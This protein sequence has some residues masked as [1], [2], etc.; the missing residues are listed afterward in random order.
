M[1]L[2]KDYFDCPHCDIKNVTYQILGTVPEEISDFDETSEYIRWGVFNLL[3]RCSRKEC[4]RV[5]YV[6]V[7]NNWNKKEI[8]Y[9]NANNQII[10]QYPSQK[11]DLPD[12]IPANIRKYFKEAVE[13]FSFGLY[14]SASMMCRKVIYE[15]CDK[16]SSGGEDYKEKIINLGFDKRIT[17]PLLN[18]KNI[19][20]DTVHANGW[21]KGTIK[22]ALEAVGIIIEMVY[23]QEQRI[24]QFSSSYSKKVQKN[25]KNS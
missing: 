14:N 7:I 23:V 4:Q 21:D 22:E 19:G 20:D 12:Y 16:K 5:T 15:L 6:R 2:D 18:I 11:N 1:Y 10:F 25:K 3:L 17:D 24:K 8:G 13:A 9:E